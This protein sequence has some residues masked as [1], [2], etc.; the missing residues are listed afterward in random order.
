MQHILTLYGQVYEQFVI[1]YLN[2]LLSGGSSISVSYWKGKLKRAVAQRFE[3]A[4]TEE[5][6][7]PEFDPRPLVDVCVFFQRL[8][9]MNGCVHTHTLLLAFASP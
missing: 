4:L 1:G 6:S 9:Q 7:S 2:K 8:A 5:E 3:R